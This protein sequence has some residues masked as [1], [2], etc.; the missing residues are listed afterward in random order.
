VLKRH[1]L[2]TTG[3]TQE[4]RVLSEPDVPRLIVSSRL[5]EAEKFERWIFEEVLPSIRKTGSYLSPSQRADKLELENTAMRLKLELFEEYHE[6]ILYDFDQ[7][8]AAIGTY[9]K[10]PFGRNHL[11]DWLV[12][13]GILCKQHCKN[14][15]PIQKYIDDKWFFPLIHEWKRNR[16]RRYE[17]RYLITQRGFNKLVDLAIQERL[18]TLPA[19]ANQCLPFEPVYRTET[20]ITAV[21][22]RDYTVA[23]YGQ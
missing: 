7:M 13:H 2:E 9:H 11:K 12:K 23:D 3:G 16:N 18:I 22:Q 15:K 10:P 19:P 1:P 6:E 4:F 5:P 17:F 8:A 21:I 20:D 14:D